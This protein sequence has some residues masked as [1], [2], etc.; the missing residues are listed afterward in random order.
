M[1]TTVGHVI[2][3]ALFF[4]FGLLCYLLDPLFNVSEKTFALPNGKLAPVVCL[5]CGI[6]GFADL[7]AGR[8]SYGKPWFSSIGVHNVHHFIMYQTYG[9]IAVCDMVER[10]WKDLLPPRAGIAAGCLAFAMEGFLFLGHFDSIFFFETSLHLMI[11][12]LAAVACIACAI[13]CIYP[14]AIHWRFIYLYATC[15]KGAVFIVTGLWIH[16][17]LPRRKE[18]REHKVPKTYQHDVVMKVHIHVGVA[19]I[20]LAVVFALRLA[21]ALRGTDYS[22][23]ASDEVA[24]GKRIV[25]ADVNARERGSLP[26]P[27]AVG[28]FSE[29]D[30]DVAATL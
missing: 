16:W 5:G 1:A 10:R 20:L 4:M 28:A 8:L 12:S 14:R 21:H 24:N 11:I 7:F 13:H 19:A 27:E 17:E 6:A 23:I 25:P 15:L 9:L 26:R 29:F 30:D 2:P 3:G 18:Y 22:R